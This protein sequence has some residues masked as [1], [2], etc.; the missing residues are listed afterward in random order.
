MNTSK[1]AAMNKNV[2]SNFRNLTFGLI[3]DRELVAIQTKE[4]TQNGRQF[5]YVKNRSLIDTSQQTY[6][7]AATFITQNKRTLGI[8]RLDEIN[9]VLDAKIICVIEKQQGFIGFFRRLLTNINQEQQCLE[10]LHETVKVA[11]KDVIASRPQRPVPSIAI[12]NDKIPSSPARPAPSRFDV[13][14]KIPSISTPKASPAKVHSEK[15]SKNKTPSP[16]T[17]PK[18]AKTDVPASPSPSKNRV[19]P[20]TAIPTPPVQVPT[21]LAQVPSAPAPAAPIMPPPPTPVAPRPLPSPNAKQSDI[22]NRAETAPSMLERKPGLLQAPAKFGPPAMPP[23][24]QLFMNEPAPLPKTGDKA[25]IPGKYKNVPKEVL[26]EEINII[27]KYLKDLEESLLPVRTTINDAAQLETKV[28]DLKFQLTNLKTKQRGLENTLEILLSTPKDEIAHLEYRNKKDNKLISN[29]PFYPDSV[30]LEINN[31]REMEWSKRKKEKQDQGIKLEERQRPVDLQLIPAALSKE[32]AIH[33]FK[34]EKL[35]IDR[36]L[37]KAQNNLDTE[38]AKLQE[39]KNSKNNN[40]AFTSFARLI[41]VRDK[42]IDILK[43][44]VKNR[45]SEIKDQE[46]GKAP[47]AN[48]RPK[49]EIESIEVQNE[50]KIEYDSLP[51]E[52]LVQLRNQDPELQIEFLKKHILFPEE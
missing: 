13:P 16:S 38:T 3:K 29:T 30:R 34:A 9:K 26:T 52:V 44:A 7:K 32:T 51:Q 48:S 20:L 25:I 36:N 4:S 27:Q 50:Q 2:I 37:E 31:K 43:N 19:L 18:A 11:M 6:M 40:I 23:A 14:N 22:L 47:K 17:L 41:D 24:A 46:S 8:S 21:P 49:E 15:N 10:F 12:A 1:D 39:I 5:I 33:V 35:E 45:E 42:Q 28:N